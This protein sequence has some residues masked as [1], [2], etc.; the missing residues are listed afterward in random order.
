MSRKKNVTLEQ[1]EDSAKSANRLFAGLAGVLVC[2]VTAYAWTLGGGSFFQGILA[3]LEYMR[4]GEYFFVPGITGA[5]A[6]I[7][8]G[9][10]SGGIIYFVAD[11]DHRRTFTYEAG[12][13]QGDA[14]PMSRKELMEYTKRYVAKEPDDDLLPKEN[15]I[16][17]K[18]MK[19]P[20]DGRVLGNNNVFVIGGA[21]SGKSFAY[22][23]TNIMQMY[24]SYIVT[25]PSGELI[26]ATGKMLSEHGYKIKVFNI[27]DMA[28]SNCYNPLAYIRNEA[29][30]KMVVET[31]IKNTSEPG[32]KDDQF[33]V[34]AEKLLYS[35]CIFYLT[36]FCPDESKKNFP[37]V[38]KMINK[39]S[40][41]ENNASFESELD[42]LFKPLPS[43]SL[44]AQ[45]YRSFKQAAGKTLKSIII[46][47]VARL[48][49]FLVPQVIQLTCRDELELEKFGNERTALFII[50][51]QADRTY[52]FLASMLYSQ[53]FETLYAVA[54]KKLQR[55]GSEKLN[56]PVMALMDEFGNIGE[57]PEFPNKLATMRK[58]NISASVILQDLA[59][60]KAMYDKEWA[61]VISN[62]S[63]WLFLGATEQET[64]EY[65]SKRTGNRTIRVRSS[66]RSFGKNSSASQNYQESQRA[67]LTEDELS[68][69]LPD[70][71]VVYTQNMRPVI[72]HKYFAN[73]H[74]RYPQTG[75]KDYPDNNF[76]Y[77]EMPAYD[78]GQMKLGSL[79]RA[80]A[81]AA[82]IRAESVISEP[83]LA[84]DVCF[85]CLD[86]ELENMITL[87][88]SLDEAAYH[89]ALDQCL[90]Q[91]G[92]SLVNQNAVPFFAV[93]DIPGRHL[94]RLADDISRLY[95][96]DRFLLLCVAE[97]I[98]PKRMRGICIDRS[99]EG[100]LEAAEQ[101]CPKSFVRREHTD[102]SVYAE[103]EILKS[104]FDD[105][106]GRVNGLFMTQAAKWKFHPSAQS[107][108]VV[109]STEGS[110]LTKTSAQDILIQNQEYPE[111]EKMDAQK[112]LDAEKAP[113]RS[114]EGT[115]RY[116]LMPS[117]I[118]WDGPMDDSMDGFEA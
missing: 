106:R 10:V 36:E 34:S 15:I 58:Y 76:Q 18:E 4:S 95:G 112:I 9:G 79:L 32:S 45:F 111:P 21:G 12:K 117:Q 74:P 89:V 63:S 7:V 107:G 84:K 2:Y 81:E 113:E 6:G 62:C 66:G 83:K 69:L 23:K 57:V 44:A 100:V 105:Y 14:K 109:D 101:A 24:G 8:S 43:G 91:Y 28:H 110:K 56:V 102:R 48:Q 40:I 103:V 70:Q 87:P 17:C 71:C 20:I 93:K 54:E 16:L 67:V 59:Q 5:F 80:K 82:R 114:A 86:N 35:A 97:D 92:E 50:T 60:L 116:S 53:L 96:T 42:K 31:L 41:D 11:L 13:S 118:L 104:K 85:D 3:V 108:G 27:S 47:C 64:L 26:N 78:T 37:E 33:F 90:E 51:P 61:S 19:R 29:G 73:E 65:F 55:T 94:L 22:V 68:R 1:R 52:S 115:G 72:G 49:S 46:S 25:D 99:R 88:G 98:N 39:S 77:T 75:S 30:V 38:M